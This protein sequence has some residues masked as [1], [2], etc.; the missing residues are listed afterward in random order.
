MA[1]TEDLAA[2]FSV[3][4]FASTATLEGATVQAIVDAES[5]IEVDGLVTQAPS[6]LLTTAQAGSAEPGDAFVALGTTYSVRR[7][8]REPPDGAM[9]RLVLARA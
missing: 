6:A 3:S 8:L 9:T 7:V 4:E 5:V 1:M 2:F